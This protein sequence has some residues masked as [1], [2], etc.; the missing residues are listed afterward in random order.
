MSY[1]LSI[2][3]AA[4]LD[5]ERAIDQ[6]EASHELSDEASEALGAAKEAAK[7]LATVVVPGGEPASVSISG[8]ANPG[9][10][11]AEGWANDFVAVTV[12][13][14]TEPATAPEPSDPA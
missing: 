1:S 4:G 10:K 6:A 14:A 8:H 11:P 7:A 5:L 13:Q 9:H 3:P 2:G 12:T